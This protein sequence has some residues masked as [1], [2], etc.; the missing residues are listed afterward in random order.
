MRTKVGGP[1][2]CWP[3][4]AKKRGFIHDGERLCGDGMIASEGL[5]AKEAAKTS[6]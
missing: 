2:S 5:R 1:A 4:T 3:L 6:C